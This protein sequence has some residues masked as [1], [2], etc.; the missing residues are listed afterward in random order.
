MYVHTWI[1]IIT[2][3]ICFNAI[4]TASHTL[5]SNIA[6]SFVC[7]AIKFYDQFCLTYIQ[8]TAIADGVAKIVKSKEE[9]NTH[10]K[11][12][13]KYHYAHSTCHE[14]DYNTGLEQALSEFTDL[15]I[16]DEDNKFS[17]HNCK[18]L[19]YFMY[20]CMYQLQLHNKCIFTTK[21]INLSYSVSASYF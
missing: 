15:D 5:C 16:L 19:Y 13:K 21:A 18:Q 3:F 2:E 12:E 6:S 1:C 14:A 7:I 17:C 9:L 11:E 10:L 8:E 20:G 4:S